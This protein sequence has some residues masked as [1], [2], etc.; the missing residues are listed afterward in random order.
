MKRK[1]TLLES[2]STI[3]VMMFVVCV[4]FIFFEIPV[5]PLLIISAAYA[6]WI[7]WRVGLR[8]KDL[9]EGITERLSTAMPAIFIILTVGIVVGT[10][11]YSGTVPALIYY[12]LNL[13]SPSY[14]LI[15]AFI[16]SALTSVATGTAWGSASTAG[17]ALMAI[18]MQMDIPAGMAAGAIISGAVFGDKMSPLSDTTNLAALVTRVNIFSHIKHMIWTTVPAS[19]IGLIVWYI[20][21]SRLSMPTNTAQ[22]DALLKDITTMYHINFFVWLPLI[23]IVICLL[24]KIS[25]VPSMLISS[26]VAILVGTLNHGFQLKDGFVA[27]LSGFKPDMLNQQNGL[28]EKALSLIEQGGMMSMTQVLVTIFCGYAFAGIVEKAGCLDVILQSISKNIR[29]RGQLVLVTIVGSLMMVLAAGVASVVIIMVGVLLMPMYDK[30][31]LD[32]VNL[33]R[34]LEDSGTMVIPLIPWGTS[35]IYY[36]QQLGVS[37]GEFFV[38]AVPCYLCVII[39][40]LYGFTGISIKKKV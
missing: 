11:M 31:G 6:S 7:A 21:S 26:V 36:T 16:I 2:L 22:I 13:M 12:G 35:G 25:T 24:I 38:W 29:S 40:L 39:A 34:T 9:E 4:G 5:Q 32:R 27:T 8:W 30:L 28:S 3:I 15:S 19:I 14:F 17:I 10:W 33:S 20:A 37:V 18:G 1:P 23:V